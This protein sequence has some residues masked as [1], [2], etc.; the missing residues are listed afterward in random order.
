MEKWRTIGLNNKFINAPHS[1]AVVKTIANRP[2]VYT[3]NDVR[4]PFRVVSSLKR[5]L[6]RAILFL[7][8]LQR[9]EHL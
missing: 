8:T 5:F 7:F 1:R 3:W 4:L 6:C 9:N 2:S